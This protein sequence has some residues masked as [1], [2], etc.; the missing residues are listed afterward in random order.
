MDLDDFLAMEDE[1]AQRWE[2]QIKQHSCPKCGAIMEEKQSQ[3]YG[4]YYK[5]NKCAKNYQVVNF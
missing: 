1:S 3:Q 2:D 4:K 5:C